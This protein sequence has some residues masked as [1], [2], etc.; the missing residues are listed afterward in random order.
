[1]ENIF[2]RTIKLFIGLF[3]VSLG[4]VLMIN[5]NVG[6]VSWD[7]LHSGVSKV[8]GVSI[9]QAI[10][11]VNIIMTIIGVIL[12]EKI[13]IGTLCN[14]I[15]IGV[16]VDFI[17][18]INIVPMNNNFIIGFFMMNLGM[19]IMALGTVMYISCEL[20]CGAKDSV[21]MGLTKLLNRP[22]KAIRSTL[23]LI[24]IVVGI[25]LGG[26]FGIL[27]I[28]G[29]FIFGYFM[30][31]TFKILGCNIGELKHLSIKD[32]LNMRRYKNELEVDYKE[33]V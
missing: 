6:M 3:L 29:A 16:F 20:G 32:M 28:Y 12:K 8:S 24:A 33:V 11:L 31:I 22:V 7:V 15:F 2:F 26:S 17:K 25:I 30:Q 1:M 23:E 14:I 10:I 27:T 21:T 18:N 5:A 4:G 19:I 9:G 13:G